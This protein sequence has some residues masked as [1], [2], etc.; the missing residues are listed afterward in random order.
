MASEDA[1]LSAQAHVSP[2]CVVS[3]GQ[4]MPTLRAFLSRHGQP[5]VLLP[6]VR[7][8][9]AAA[10]ANLSTTLKESCAKG[11]TRGLQGL[12]HSPMTKLSLYL[13][14]A[15]AADILG[16]T[17]E[18]VRQLQAANKL[19]RKTMRQVGYRR[20]AHLERKHVEA[21]KLLASPDLRNGQ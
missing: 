8:V 2:E 13:T 12:T 7:G 20:I 15:E 10:P 19:G 18:R 6:A 5:A 11:L 17:V 9:P 3:R 14:I 1:G 21:R 16:V 4:S